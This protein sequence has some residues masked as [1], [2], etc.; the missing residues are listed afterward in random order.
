MCIWSNNLWTLKF[1]CPSIPSSLSHRQRSGAVLCLRHSAESGNLF[2]SSQLVSFSPSNMPSQTPPVPF[3][4]LTTL[5]HHPSR[6]GEAR[7]L[8][9]GSSCCA[10]LPLLFFAHWHSFCITKLLINF[11]DRYPGRFQSSAVHCSDYVKDE[12]VPFLSFLWHFSVS[13]KAIH[14]LLQ[15]TFSDPGAVSHLYLPTTLCL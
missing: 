2:L 8:E 14:E 1:K 15:G 10:L 12:K 7:H 6:R 13:L 5:Q 4:Y 11:P 3:L 9:V